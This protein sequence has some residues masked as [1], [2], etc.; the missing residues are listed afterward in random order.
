MSPARVLLRAIGPSLAAA[1]VPGALT[2]PILEL[3]DS[4]G[5][6]LRANDNW[7]D[8]QAAEIEATRGP[9]E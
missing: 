9:A 5:G 1:G 7:R 4:N 3:R 6:I 8:T 2:D